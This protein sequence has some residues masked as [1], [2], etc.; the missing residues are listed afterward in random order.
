MKGKFTLISMLLFLMFSVGQLNAQWLIYTGDTVPS[1]ELVIAPGELDFTTLSDNNAGDNMV[2]TCMPDPDIDGNRIFHYEQT[3]DEDSTLCY[4]TD[5]ADIGFTDSVFTVVVRMKGAGYGVDTLGVGFEFRNGAAGTRAKLTIEPASNLI[6]LD[7]FE[8]DVSQ[9]TINPTANASGGIGEIARLNLDLD[10][11]HIYR[12][13]V[14]GD[15]YKVYI[16]EWARYVI[17]G[18]TSGTTS[19]QYIKFGDYGGDVYAG[20]IDYI[21]LDT[22][23]AW[24]PSA[25]GDNNPDGPVLPA[26]IRDT[27]VHACVASWDFDGDLTDAVGGHD[28]TAYGGGDDYVTALTDE[29][30]DLTVNDTVKGILAIA[31]AADLMFGINSFSVVSIVQAPIEGVDAAIANEQFPI[32]FG[33]FGSNITSSIHPAE[34]VRYGLHMKGTQTRFTIDD[35]GAKVQVDGQ[36]ERLWKRGDYNLV[37]GVRDAEADTVRVYLNGVQIGTKRDRCGT[38]MPIDMP[39]AIGGTGHDNGARLEGQIDKVEIYNYALTPAEIEAMYVGVLDGQEPEPVAHWDFSEVT[40]DTVADIT[41]NGAT[42]KLVGD[43]LVFVE[44][45]DGN[46][47]DLAQSADTSIIYVDWKDSEQLDFDSVSFTL[48]ALVNT[49]PINTTGEMFIMG[50]G[51]IQNGGYA[52]V[53]T[54]E[55]IGKGH[56]YT[57]ATKSGEIRFTTDSHE[58][59]NPTDGD[60]KSQLGVSVPEYPLQ[61]WAHIVGMRDIE[62]SKLLLYVNGDTI[63]TR[64]DYT[65]IMDLDSCPFWIGNYHSESNQ[66]DGL[67]DD[68]QI[69]D[70]ALTKDEVQNLYNVIAQEIV[71]NQEPVVLSANIS[72]DADTVFRDGDVVTPATFDLWGE[73]A[74]QD[75][76]PF[77][78]LTF[79][80]EVNTELTP[81]T[82]FAAT[83]D[84]EYKDTI[85]SVSLDTA[86]APPDGYDLI[87]TFSV[88]DGQYTVSED[89]EL[90]VIYIDRTVGIASIFKN[91]ERLLAYPTI[92][93][94][95]I[96][97]SAPEALVGEEVSFFDYSGKLAK[98]G[99]LYSTE[100][101]FNISELRPGAYIIRIKNSTTTIIKR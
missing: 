7:T 64:D 39:L 48:S 83:F 70:A 37:V 92:S 51:I 84:N 47:V 36:S 43:K 42:G 63:G 3:D 13:A 53:L 68:I 33:Q 76:I 25:G 95:S 4:R 19:D 93:R 2:D 88:S 12:I 67:I 66:L 61:Q 30:L 79:K 82:L 89:V 69:F 77:D 80:W 86:L 75:T 18:K 100:S 97:I 45:L 44:G 87:I 29:A 91:N 24:G 31:D 20:Y 56:F 58:G 27:A 40:A 99:T 38:M 15:E 78:T 54:G 21:L 50:N 72:H 26:S 5:F 1:E 94:G 16:D 9:D 22:S 62:S 71:L 85:V 32:L 101:R 41:G 65:G 11:W 14:N 6:S 90:N 10:E 60:G 96:T 55:T 52:D 23:G 35:D 98:V 8:V 46:A 34:G 59:H 28:L 49:D 73:G 57:L 17:S 81:D 74:D